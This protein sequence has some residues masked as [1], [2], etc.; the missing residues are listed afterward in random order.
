MLAFLKRKKKNLF[1][2]LGSFATFETETGSTSTHLQLSRIRTS[3]GSARDKTVKIVIVEARLPQENIRVGLSIFIK[4]V[5]A[6]RS[7]R[8][9]FRRR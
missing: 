4:P 5:C 6:K 1:S 3:L 7:S 8:L 2:L 9:S